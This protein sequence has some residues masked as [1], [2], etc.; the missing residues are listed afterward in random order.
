MLTNGVLLLYDNA[1]PH[2]AAWT[3]GGKHFDNGKEMKVAVSKW[4]REQAAEFYAAGIQN[5]VW[6]LFCMFHMISTWITKAIM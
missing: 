5:L 3:L 1:R 2:T 4:L 6:H